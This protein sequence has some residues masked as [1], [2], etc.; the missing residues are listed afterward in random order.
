MGNALNLM[1]DEEKKYFD[2]RGEHEPEGYSQSLGEDSEERE[3]SIDERTSEEPSEG[4]DEPISE[5]DGAKDSQSRVYDAPESVEHQPPASNKS[6]K[7]DFEKAYGIAES[8]RQELHAQ[9]EQQARYNQQLQQQM[10][11]LMQ[12]QQGGQRAQEAAPKAPDPNED[13]LGYLTYQNEYLNK[14]VQTHQKY[15]EQQA[16]LYQ[17][18]QSMSTFV[19]AYK[20]SANE[21]SKETPDFMDAYKFLEQSRI[22]EYMAAG[23]SEREAAQLLQEDEMAVAAKAFRENANPAQRVYALAKAR[24][25]SA[26]SDETKL[27]KVSKGMQKGKTLPRAGGKNMERG[28]D[29]SMIDE[30]S[31][32]EFDKFFN[33]VKNEAKK[34]GDYKKDFY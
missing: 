5:G 8:K 6:S 2:T 13:P 9:L 7:R 22:N 31:E 32:E 29:I 4:F 17:E 27:E 1:N 11:M 15:L 21:F 33:Q 12:Q 3:A 23:Y 18:Q 25:Y 14:T 34:S 26:P 24:G 10:Q 28:Y 16:K 30:M 19:N 20:A